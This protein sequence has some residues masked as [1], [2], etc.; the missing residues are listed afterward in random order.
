MVLR[1][2]FGPLEGEA[3]LQKLMGYTSI[4]RLIGIP[5]S[6]VRAQFLNFEKS[7]T[8]AKSMRDSDGI[9]NDHKGVFNLLQ[10][11]ID[12]LCAESTLK[13]WVSPS[14]QERCVLFHRQFPDKFI[15]PWRLRFVYKQ[16][17]IK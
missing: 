8:N 9:E 12:F 7:R 2:R 13:S 3:H 16:N 15:K 5:Y 17:L 10:V 11:H 4:S 6:T 1:L 14:I